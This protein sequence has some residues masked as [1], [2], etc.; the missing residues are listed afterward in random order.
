MNSKVWW[1]KLCLFFWA[2]QFSFGIRKIN[3]NFLLNRIFFLIPI[4]TEFTIALMIA[5]I[6]RCKTNTM[7]RIA[8]IV[9]GPTIAFIFPEFYWFTNFFYI[10]FILPIVLCWIVLNHFFYKL[11][12]RLL[13]LLLNDLINNRLLRSNDLAF[14]MMRFLKIMISSFRLIICFNPTFLDYFIDNFTYNQE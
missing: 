5:F 3:L 11:L 13:F 14:F 4:L 9:F 10:W 8:F 2:G 1:C 7:S 6:L 12:R